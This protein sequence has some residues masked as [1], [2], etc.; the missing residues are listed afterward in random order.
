MITFSVGLLE[1]QARK[2]Q[3]ELVAVM[4][5][6]NAE[7]LKEKLSYLHIRVVSG[8]EGLIFFVADINTTVHDRFD[9]PTEIVL[10][11]ALAKAHLR[12]KCVI[13][14]VKIIIVPMARCLALGYDVFLAVRRPMS[15]FLVFHNYILLSESCL[16]VVGVAVS[17]EIVFL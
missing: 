5:E 3:P 2:F 1:K 6:K 15:V 11:K 9:A 10:R 4:D 13:A 14:V 17:C 7:I 8:M 12:G 16:R